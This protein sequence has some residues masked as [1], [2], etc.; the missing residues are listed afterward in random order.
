MKLPALILRFQHRGNLGSK[1]FSLLR[2]FRELFQLRRFD[3]RWVGLLLLQP[4]VD[5]SGELIGARTVHVEK[6]HVNGL[7]IVE[8]VQ[9]EIGLRTILDGG[10][11]VG[12]DREGLSV[13]LERSRIVADLAIGVSQVAPCRIVAGVLLRGLVKFLDRVLV[14][15]FGL[16]QKFFLLPSIVLRLGLLLELRGF[17]PVRNAVVVQSIRLLLPSTVLGLGIVAIV[18]RNDPDLRW[19]LVGVLG[20]AVISL[21]AIQRQGR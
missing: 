19:Y 2:P 15:V 3:A 18:L 11:V 10:G 7:H 9:G 4:L 14:L 5:G 12:L 16:G 21:A 6:H 8:L 20:S 1:L 13:R 17:V